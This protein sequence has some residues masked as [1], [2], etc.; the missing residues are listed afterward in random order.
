MANLI[1]FFFK[2]TSY[3][4]IIFT[5]RSSKKGRKTSR[6]P[7]RSP[8]ESLEKHKPQTWFFIPRLWFMS[9]V[10]FSSYQ[11]ARGAAQS[12]IFTMSLRSVPS[13]IM[14]ACAS[15]GYTMQNWPGRSMKYSVA[16]WE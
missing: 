13:P 11:K 16:G 15:S 14:G 3:P 8:P 7:I 2:Y 5:F 12:R 10:P 1:L 4:L 6:N 9:K